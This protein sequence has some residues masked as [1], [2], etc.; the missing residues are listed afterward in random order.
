MSWEPVEEPGPV[1]L[2]IAV[3]GDGVNDSD[4]SVVVGSGAVPNVKFVA[5]VVVDVLAIVFHS[6]L[7]PHSSGTI[8]G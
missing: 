4:T 2:C 1:V 8:W 3:T 5:V 7:A 6:D